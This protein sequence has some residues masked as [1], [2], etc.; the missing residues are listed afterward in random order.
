LPGTLEKLLVYYR[1]QLE[2]MRGYIKEAGKRREFEAAIQG[3]IQDIEQ[4]QSIV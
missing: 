1:H 2:M 4:L 3:W